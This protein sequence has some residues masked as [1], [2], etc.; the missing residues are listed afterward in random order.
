VPIRSLVPLCGNVGEAG[1]DP[2]KSGAPDVGLVRAKTWQDLVYWL[3]HIAPNG[4]NQGFYEEVVQTYTFHKMKSV[5]AAR[6]RVAT[7]IDLIAYTCLKY[8]MEADG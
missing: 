2:A 3:G 1:H 5:S 8:L 7:M 6:A 4:G